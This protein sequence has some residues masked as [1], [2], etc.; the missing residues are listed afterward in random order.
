MN[1]SYCR[2]ST[3]GFQCDLYVYES[4]EGYMIHTAQ[5]RIVG[6]VPRMPSIFDVTAEEWTRQHRKQMEFI[7]TAKREKIEGEFANNTFI[8]RDLE[9][10][11]AR[12]EMLRAAGF[13][14]PD[15]VLTALREELEDEIKAAE[16]RNNGADHEEA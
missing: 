1:V 12:L 2:F 13:R 4:A 15:D 3:D 9:D 8:E 5:N 7:R 6:E 14:F 10:A 11:I 16:E